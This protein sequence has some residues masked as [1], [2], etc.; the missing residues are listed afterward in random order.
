[1]APSAFLSAAASS[2]NLQ[3]LILNGGD[4][5]ITGWESCAVES[6]GTLCDAPLPS[7]VAAY[8][9]STWDKPVVDSSFNIIMSSL[10]DASDKARLLAAAAPHSGAWLHALPISNCGLRLDDEAVRVAVGLRLG[11]TLCLPHPCQCGRVVDPQG[12]HAW[13]C[14][15]ASA[16][17]IRHTAIVVVS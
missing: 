14:K 16:R 9:Q 7:G 6:W 2:R 15:R 10:V 8:R 11:T 12:A 13:S 5:D 4:V 3:G 17:I 1:M